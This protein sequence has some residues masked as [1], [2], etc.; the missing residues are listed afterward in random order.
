[1]GRRMLGY[2]GVTEQVVTSQEA[3]VSKS[4]RGNLGRHDEDFS[5]SHL[6]PT[7]SDQHEAEENNAQ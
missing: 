1:M 2:N 5:F 4:Y 6:H 3:G 7:S